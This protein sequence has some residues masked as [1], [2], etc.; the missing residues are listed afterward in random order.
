MY[1]LCVYCE[2]LLDYNFM[3]LRKAI[4]DVFEQSREN[5]R[6]LRERLEEA[7]GDGRAEGEGGVTASQQQIIGQLASSLAGGRAAGP[8]AQV[9]NGVHAP[10]PS[11]SSSATPTRS[12][13]ASLNRLATVSNPAALRAGPR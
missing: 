10:S 8:L 1:Q 4:E 7:S 11:A 12:S 2:A 5:R 6:T 3:C 13:G 9:L